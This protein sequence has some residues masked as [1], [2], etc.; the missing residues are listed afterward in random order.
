MKT[1]LPAQAKLVTVFSQNI[2]RAARGV[3][4]PYH[5]MLD[6]AGRCVPIGPVGGD[7]YDL[8]REDPGSLSLLV[9]D[10][11]GHDREASLVMVKAR[12]CFQALRRFRFDAESLFMRVNQLLCRENR[13]DRFVTTGLVQLNPGSGL[14]RT[15]LAGHPSPLRVTT[16][17]EVTPLSAPS[18]LPLGICP[19]FR[20]KASKTYQLGKGD[21]LL[22]YSDGLEET[23]NDQ[24]ETFGSGRLS[25]IL[26]EVRFCS[27]EEILEILLDRVFVFA[28]NG[29]VPDDTTAVVVRVR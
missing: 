8:F 3:S 14:V 11:M 5:G 13:W 21:L 1:S 7:W 24:G 23:T 20:Y 26:R 28:K 19:E 27:C 16:R 17:G 2:S 25:D 22:L 4:V 29:K 18:N 15:L 10:V 12:A 9:G 6:F